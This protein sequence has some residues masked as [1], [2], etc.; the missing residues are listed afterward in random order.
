MDAICKSRVFDNAINPYTG[1]KM[2]VHLVT[3]KTGQVMF[4][5]PGTYSTTNKFATSH[6]VIRE[7]SRV[8]GVSGSRHPE[9]GV[10]CAYTGEELTMNK[11]PETGEYW[12]SGGFDP[13]ILHTREEFL[14]Y[15][16]MRD[17]NSPYKLEATEHVT[18]PEEAVPMAKGHAPRELDGSIEAA[19]DAIHK[20]GFK[21]KKRTM[22]Q[23]EK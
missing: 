18:K 13:T 21:T 14:Y 20:S 12:L 3:M 1:K 11:D 4:Y 17:G 15:V 22:V 10:R 23:V 16:Y 7:W 6:D 5:A 19:E 8:N 2:E 9:S